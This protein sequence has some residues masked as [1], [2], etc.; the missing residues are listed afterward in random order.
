MIIGTTSSQSG[1]KHNYNV[2]LSNISNSGNYTI[3]NQRT[4]TVNFKITKNWLTGT[5]TSEEEAA[6]LAVNQSGKNVVWLKLDKIKNSE[7]GAYSNTWTSEDGYANVLTGSDPDVSTG[8]PT[9]Y[10]DKW[11]TTSEYQNGNYPKYDGL[12][13]IY[14]YSVNEV[15]ILLK[16]NGTISDEAAGSP[17]LYTVTETSTDGQGRDVLSGLQV[18]ATETD[19][20]DATLYH[21]YTVSAT[22]TI[23]YAESLGESDKYTYEVTNKRAQMLTLTANK[24][25]QDDGSSA[26]SRPDITF[27]IYRTSK[28]ESAE[29][30]EA[31]F[32]AKLGA[33]NTNPTK[34]QIKKAQVEFLGDEE[35]ELVTIGNETRFKWNT[36][37][38][39]WYW[40]S[41]RFTQNERYDEKGNPY[42]YFLIETIPTDTDYSTRYVNAHIGSTVGAESIEAGNANTELFTP[43]TKNVSSTAEVFQPNYL[44]STYSSILSAGFLIVTDGLHST[45]VEDGQIVENS[46]EG[47]SQDYCRYWSRT[48]INYKEA[49]TNVNGRKIWKLPNGSSIDESYLP[50][51]T[52]RIR[53]Q[54]GQQNGSSNYSYVAASDFTQNVDS[55]DSKLYVTL[56]TKA[57]APQTNAN[58]SVGNVTFSGTNKYSYKITGLPKYDAYGQQYT[59]SVEEDKLEEPYSKYFDRTG[60]SVSTQDYINTYTGNPTATLSFTKIWAVAGSDG[61]NTFTLDPRTGMIEVATGNTS[62]TKQLPDSLT[63]EI[64]GYASTESD[65]KRDEVDSAAY[66]VTLQPNYFD[67]PGTYTVISSIRCIGGDQ[68]DGN[69]K[70]T[71]TVTTNSSET[72]ATTA[73]WTVSISNLKSIAPDGSAII[74]EVQE[75]PVPN[76]YQLTASDNDNMTLTP[77]ASSGNV[78]YSGAEF[79]NTYSGKKFDDNGNGS[80]TYVQAEKIWENDGNDSWGRRP[81]RINL[82]LYRSIKGNNH[83]QNTDY[84]VGT[85]SLTSTNS[86]KATAGGTAQSPTLLVYAPDG[87]EFDYYLIEVGEQAPSYEHGTGSCVYENGVMKVTLTNKLSTGI[88]YFQKNWKTQLGSAN[89]VDMTEEEFDRLLAL[90]A[91]PTITIT[92]QYYSDSRW[93][94]LLKDG[95]PVQTTFS[96]DPN[97]KAKYT[98]YKNLFTNKNKISYTVPLYK[99]GTNVAGQDGVNY[100]E[101]RIKETVQYGNSA[102]VDYYSTATDATAGIHATGDGNST[103]ADHTAVL[104]NTIPVQQVEIIK[105]WQD[106]QNQD[107]QRPDNL[108]ITLK[109]NASADATTTVTASPVIATT[110]DTTLTDEQKSSGNYYSTGVILIPAEFS[111]EAPTGF[112]VNSM[113]VTE[114]DVTEKGY[115][116]TSDSP[117]KDSGSYGDVNVTTFTFTNVYAPK[118]FHISATKAWNDEDNR[119]GLRNTDDSIALTL[120]YSLDNGSTWTTIPTA[121]EEQKEYYHIGGTNYLY[122][123]GGAVCTTTDG[124]GVLTS[125]NSGPTVTWA[126]LPAKALV[127]GASVEV[128]YKITEDDGNKAY[129]G[130]AD[131]GVFEGTIKY[132]DSAVQSF[133]ITNSLNTTSLMIQKE[134]K[135]EGTDGASYR[136]DSISFQVEYRVGDSGTWTNLPGL[137]DG[138]VT[139]AKPADAS[140]AWKRELTGLP[141]CDK[142]GTNYQY[143]VSEVSLTYTTASGTQSD[144]AKNGAF[145]DTEKTW[146]ADMGRYLTKVTT[147]QKEDDSWTASAEN[148]LIDR[149]NLFTIEVSKQWEDGENRF[150]L[151]P[152]NNGVELSL[153]YSLDGG[154]TW[155]DITQSSLNW[156]NC[157]ADNYNAYTTSEPTQTAVAAGNGKAATPARWENLPAKVL[158]NGVSTKVKYRVTEPGISSAYSS[159]IYTANTDGSPDTE[160]DREDGTEWQGTAS[161]VQK[162]VI[163]NT[164]DTVSLT[165]SKTWAGED[166]VTDGEQYRPQKAAFLIEYALEGEDSWEPLPAGSYRTEDDIITVGTD[167]LVTLTPDSWSM[168]I[169]GLAKVDT[170]GTAYQYRVSEA[171]LTYQSVSLPVLRDLLPGNT[172]TA[173]GTF[174]SGENEKTWT[175]DAGRYLAKVTTTK[176]AD[177]SWTASAKNTFID[178]HNL[179]TI[180]V[181][182]Q[183]EDGENRFGL[184]PESNGVEL[185]LQ[186][187]L[188]GGTTWSE[189][190]KDSLNWDNCYNDNYSA[191]TTSEPT[192]TAVAAGNGKA[193]TPA[194]WENLPAKVLVNGVSTKVKYRV[195]EPGISAAYSPEIYTAKADG[196]IDQKTDQKAGTAWKGTASEVQKFVIVNTLNTISLTVSKEW[197][198]EDGVK[199]AEALRPEKIEVRLEYALSGDADTWKTLPAGTYRTG[200][201]STVEVG[202][203]GLLTLTGK[204]GWETSLVG[205]RP[206]SEDGQTYSY[207]AQETKLIYQDGQSYT[208]QDADGGRYRVSG[209]TIQE[210]DGMF[211]SVLTNQL[212]DR[213]GARITKHALTLDGQALQGAGYVLYRPAQMDYYTGQD[214]EGNALWG[215]WNDAKILTTGEDGT[216]TVTGLPR[217]DYQFI[218]IAAAK[219]YRIDS[220]PVAFTIGDDNIGTLCEVHQADQKRSRGKHSSDRGHNSQA[221]VTDL[222]PVEPS[223]TGD[224]DDWRLYAGLAAG[225]LLA[226]GGY[227]LLRRRRRS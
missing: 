42:I 191:Y 150:G 227:L 8:I 160:V 118:L 166:A 181:S 66:I 172:D 19:Q 97:D 164:M 155:S 208:V 87:T 215:I 186:Y 26:S 88:I 221:A 197:T 96:P 222:Q 37:N 129:T 2:Y 144:A 153:Q 75:T 10:L 125:T 141:L 27:S 82:Y 3:Y 7:T 1:L 18:T 107:G 183:W 46:A 114:A 201:G 143:R 115:T 127:D 112:E 214:A 95:N 174:G 207:R 204:D 45:A 135:E 72:D 219:G 69:T 49:T 225:A 20:A 11:K 77:D 57:G 106:N 92:V 103:I 30:L 99:E 182:K 98:A 62:I 124:N 196:S 158:V 60:T 192:Q 187:S 151:R 179:F 176:N 157:Y 52:F 38:N 216:V 53:R 90:G 58:D 108:T 152:E 94:N 142:N 217:G 210:K 65:A 213:Y 165:L 122:Y 61:T 109:K 193:A 195:T 93:T 78:S 25:W 63:F 91:L 189:I 120:W 170:E 32:K 15:A 31:A 14:T 81:E 17:E 28:Y 5:S 116:A 117:V 80:Y 149:Y 110:T 212:V 70:P 64:K 175:G 105:E 145:D 132:N 9:E 47:A 22:R 40:N 154:T 128:L 205:L 180:E 168:T 126:N 54:S 134:W 140:G 163:V 206:Y 178:R 39:D 130:S 224:T 147:T 137:T 34:E 73:N 226:C 119:Y 136:P 138:I 29:A 177:S 55:E 148:S 146:T 43:Q 199:G 50:N 35:T 123:E 48:V 51:V 79:T 188:D 21:N 59:Y 121:G 85:V 202:E 169:Q 36:K 68:K 111:E 184:R 223:R 23:S 12:G 211:K 194:R 133:T 203:D 161:E 44:D 198:G 56:G 209:S 24:V 102:S 104:T 86:W 84:E 76:G 200:S 156:D 185:S 167:G 139:I 159:V 131:S 41:S 33:D 89:P 71:I 6:V 220:T 100:Q 218:E 190:T 13:K 113:S 16:Y 67:E 4:G 83:D 162:F 74:Y 171:S 173:E 101:Y